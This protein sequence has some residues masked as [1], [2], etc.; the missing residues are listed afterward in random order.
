MENLKEN[1]WIYVISKILSTEEQHVRSWLNELENE[2]SQ[3][4]R[5]FP[6]G[7]ILKLIDKLTTGPHKTLNAGAVMYRARTIDKYH[8]NQFFEKIV[9]DFNQTIVNYIPDFDLKNGQNELIRLIK[10]THSKSSD[11]LLMN[12]DLDD[13]YSKYTIKGWWGYNEKE[14][15][16][17]PKGIA[18]AGR[19]NPKGISYLY[20]ADNKRTAALEVRP[21]ISQYV[22]IAEIQLTENIHL[23]DFTAQYNLEQSLK[24]VDCS[25]IL[26]VLSEY[27]SNPNYSDDSAY[28]ATQYISEYIKH[29]HDKSGKPLFDGLCFKSSLDEVGMNYVLFNVNET[30]KYQIKNSSVYQTKSLDGCLQQQLPL[31]QSTG[32]L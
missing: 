16:A 22:S 14:S 28:L 19:I 8:E 15:D 2:L 17:P 13:F 1:P 20:A 18:S 6:D 27:F 5:F 25:I 29:I 26:S 3:E 23:F 7:K 12:K 11:N 21:V 30:K 10:Y 31:L 4:N 24:D 9:T 32:Y